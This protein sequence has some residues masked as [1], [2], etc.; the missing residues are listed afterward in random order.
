MSN[1]GDAPAFTP[2]GFGGRVFEADGRI[3]RVAPFERRKEGGVSISL[4]FP[5]ATLEEYVDPPEV[6]AELAEYL[7]C[8]KRAAAPELYEALRAI[9]RVAHLGQ[10]HDALAASAYAALAKARGET[11]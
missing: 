5:F 11:A 1:Q 10:E 3:I 6:A 4:G 2:S 7:S 8:S 9:L